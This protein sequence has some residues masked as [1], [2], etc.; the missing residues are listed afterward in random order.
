MPSKSPSQFTREVEFEGIKYAVDMRR[1]KSREF[2]RRIAAMQK[3][4][5]KSEG[6]NADISDVLAVF[7][8]LFGGEVD[9]KVASVVEQAKGYDDFE[10]IMRIE[11][12]LFEAVGAKN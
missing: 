9:D 10:E 2:V 6:G 7:D 1:A 5:E 4:A 3:S 11:T 8:Y 12:A